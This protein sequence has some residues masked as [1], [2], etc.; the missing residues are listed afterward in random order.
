MRAISDGLLLRLL[1]DTRMAKCSCGLAKR[2]GTTSSQRYQWSGSRQVFTHSSTHG[3]QYHEILVDGTHGA[4]GHKPLCLHE[5]N[6][7]SSASASSEKPTYTQLQRNVSAY[8]VHATSSKQRLAA[9][10][11]QSGHNT[12]CGAL[13]CESLRT[14]ISL[15][16]NQ[17]QAKAFGIA[18]RQVLAV[19]QE[20]VPRC[21]D[22]F[23]LQPTGRQRRALG[24]NHAAAPQ[25]RPRGREP[26]RS[27]RE[28]CDDGQA[29][30]LVI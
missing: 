4:N 12:V 9:M 11:T 29:L 24:Q 27:A 17:Q 14:T 20:Q 19:Q 15:V 6:K 2:A 16:H 28:L 1:I 21:L 3:R 8:I 30:S 10:E 25:R 22:K 23:P 7:S 13:P 26:F 18:S 5:A